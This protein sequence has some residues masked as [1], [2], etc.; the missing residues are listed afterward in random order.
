NEALPSV[1]ASAADIIQVMRDDPNL[2]PLF[3]VLAEAAAASKTDPNGRPIEKSLVDAN[4]A[5]LAKISGRAYDT[6]GSDLSNKELDPNQILPVAFANLVTPMDDGN[7][8]KG[9]TPLQVIMDVIG[10]VN[11][12][13]P[14]QTDKLK[15]EDYANIS[16]NVTDFLLNKE[17][18]LEQFYEI[19]RQGT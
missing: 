12:L 18:G 13:A 1:L 11:R 2:V 16:D 8:G 4:T 7:G 10:D 14:D 9:L 15:P 17:R 6:D 19:V 5:L 3:H